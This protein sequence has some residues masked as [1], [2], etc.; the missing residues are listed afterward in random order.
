[1][2]NV[3]PRILCRKHLLGEHVECHMFAGSIKKGIK[4]KGYVDNGLIETHNL[5][6]RHDLLAEEMVKRG[7]N[8]FTP[9]HFI[10]ENVIG[11]ID[12][13]ANIKDLYNRCEECRKNIIELENK[14]DTK[15]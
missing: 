3:D 5:K 10:S 13:E 2:W 8:H 14:K 7:Y 4:I 1:M 6:S 15:E 11:K 12:S 9:L